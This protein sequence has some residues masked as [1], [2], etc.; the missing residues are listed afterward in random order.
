MLQLL[1]PTIGQAGTGLKT[2]AQVHLLCMEAVL[3]L[4]SSDEGEMNGVVVG[5]R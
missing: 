2:A 3:G 5:Q 1:V 4:N